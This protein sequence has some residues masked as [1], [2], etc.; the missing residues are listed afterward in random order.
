ML[1]RWNLQDQ[2][3]NI[4]KTWQDRPY[5][6]INSPFCFPSVIP[7]PYE[8]ER[9]DSALKIEES[10]V[11]DEAI[12][13]DPSNSKQKIKLLPADDAVG[14]VRE[15]GREKNALGRSFFVTKKGCV[16]LAPPDAR[17]RVSSL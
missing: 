8:S 10:S 12:R 2:I 14:Y 6:M 17:E 9:G 7:D 11:E 13:L 4:A 16:G 1:D 5:N 3:V 15:K